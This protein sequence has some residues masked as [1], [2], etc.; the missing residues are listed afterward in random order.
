MKLQHNFSRFLGVLTLMA[1]A[2][3]LATPARATLYTVNMTDSYTFNPNYLEIQVGDLVRWINR[4]QYEPHSSVSTQGYWDSNDLYYGET[5]TLQF[6]APGTYPY[7]DYYYGV[8]GMTGT[9]VVK[10]ASSGTPPPGLTDAQRLP[11]GTFQFT[12]TNLV[13]GKTNIIQ[14]STNLTDWVNLSTNVAS[15]DS[16]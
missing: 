13:V 10:S 3:W 6:L 11:D 16:Y 5:Y 1:G 15:A 4:D 14:A 8:L 2:F 9:I 7:E 12:V